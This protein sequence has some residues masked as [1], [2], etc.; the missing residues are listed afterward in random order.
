MT[1]TEAFPAG[2]AASG[3]GIVLGTPSGTDPDGKLNGVELL[4]GDSGNFEAG[5]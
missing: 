2:F 4:P 3:D 5:C 1:G